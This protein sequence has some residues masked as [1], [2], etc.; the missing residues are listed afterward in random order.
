WQ[1]LLGKSLPLNLRGWDMHSYRHLH[2]YRMRISKWFRGPLPLS[3]F[4]AMH[5][6]TQ[7]NALSVLDIPRS[8]PLGIAINLDGTAQQDVDHF[9]YSAR[10]R[11]PF[12][13]AERRMFERADLVV[14]R[15]QWSANSLGPDYG[16]SPDR[17]HVARNAML[18]ADVSHDEWMQANAPD[19]RPDAPVRIAWV[20]TA[21]ERKG[22]PELLQLHQQRFAER[23]ELHIIGVEQ[24]GLASPN[25]TWHGRVPRESLMQDLLPS[26]D[27]FV[28]PTVMDQLPWTVLEAA[29]VG[30][31][32]VSAD[33]G[34]IPEVIV[35]GETGFVCPPA[36]MDAYAAAIERLIADPDLRERLGRAARQRVLEQF[37][38]DRSYGGLIDRLVQLADEK[39]PRTQQVENAA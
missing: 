37:N 15:N 29:S 31:P 33:L 38:P 22:G 14:C 11:A 17:I 2:L 3:H 24:R 13:A 9:G 26:M 32:V 1:K 7:G 5:I 23:A 39:S 10:A 8:R 28:M 35:N 4:D 6:M 34:A 25:V 16:V 19:G 30:L 27:V 36:N 21:F 18:P 20:G 12:I